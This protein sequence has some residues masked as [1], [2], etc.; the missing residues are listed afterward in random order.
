MVFRGV[1]S[2]WFRFRARRTA[3]ATAAGALLSLTLS[4]IFVPPAQAAPDWNL[5]N[6]GA[7][8]A[9]DLNAQASGV[10]RNVGLGKCVDVLNAGTAKRSAAVT[11]ACSG[12]ATQNWTYQRETSLWDDGTVRPAGAATKCLTVVSNNG[13]SVQSISIG[14]TTQMLLTE[15][16]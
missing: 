16:G 6:T 8:R 14:G 1:R 10:I 15:S 11:S 9:S 4:M 12:A 5:G 2:S 7:S 3:G 13:G